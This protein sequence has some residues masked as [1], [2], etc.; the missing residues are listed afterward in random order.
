LQ[1][2][3]DTPF[4][5]LAEY[6]CRQ[7]PGGSVQGFDVF[8]SYKSDDHPWVVRLKD[9]LQLRGVRVWLDKDEIRPGDR[10]VWAL[11]R[12]LDTSRAVA[13]VV[14]PESLTSGWIA[15]EYSR[16]VALANE[17]RLHLIPVV[18]RD[19]KLPGFLSTRQHIDFRNSSA[20]DQAVDRLVWPGI[21]G[22]RIIW[23]PVFGVYHSERWRRLF[24]VAQEEGIK[25]QTG[26]DIHRSEWF[27]EPLLE[28]TSKRLVLVF[29]IF[30]ERPAAS[31][32]WRNTTEQYIEVILNYRERTKNKPNEVIFLFYHQPDAWERV[33]DVGSLRGELV[34]R[35]KH[36][37]TLN[38]DLP[39]DQLFRQKLRDVWNRIQRDLMLA[40]TS[41]N[42]AA[43][44]GTR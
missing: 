27:I 44:R 1:H 42:R 29:D 19:A 8:L 25:F 21:T 5:R 30:E 38:Q 36:Y 32:L 18:L 6:S 2:A 14:T 23:Y 15:D 4:N 40:E 13:L 35:F 37:F 7:T 3:R 11:E 41:T 28:D 20:F 31:E 22:K 34:Q 33:A 16:A 12:G 39:D 17:G 43:G 10:F 9:A 24:R 26:E